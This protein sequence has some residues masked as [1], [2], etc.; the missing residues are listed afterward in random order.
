MVLTLAALWFVRPP[1]EESPRGHSFDVL[2]RGTLVILSAI[3][4]IVTVVIAGSEPGRGSS[5][6]TWPEAVRGCPAHRHTL[7]GVSSTPTVTAR[8]DRRGALVLPVTSRLPRVPRPWARRVLLANLVGEI[9]IVVTGGVVRLT[10]SGLGC[11]TW[12]ECVPGSFT[13]VRTA[14]SA[15]HDLVEFGNRR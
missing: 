9:G 13:P 12:P 4:A 8:P 5:G 3:A 1:D 2:A 7:W 11:P 6:T 15:N 14:E 10:G